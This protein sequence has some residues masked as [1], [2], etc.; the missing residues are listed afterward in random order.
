MS[1]TASSVSIQ[2]LLLQSPHFLSRVP[3]RVNPVQLVCRLYCD[4]GVVAVVV[5]DKNLLEQKLGL[6]VLPQME[7]SI[8]DRQICPNDRRVV[9]V[10]A[11]FAHDANFR[12]LVDLGFVFYNFGF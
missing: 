11:F 7:V 8:G 3:G 5:Q 4:I 2:G 12:V 10:F 1:L 6:V 9:G